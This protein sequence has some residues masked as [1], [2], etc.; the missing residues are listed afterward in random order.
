MNLRLPNTLIRPWREG[1]AEAMAR[2]ANNRKVWLN[3][4]DVFPHPYSLE[5]AR[6]YLA[7]LA[8]SKR[9]DS[10]AIEYEGGAVGGI[11]AHRL[12]DIHRCSA[13]IGYWL[14]EPYW[15]RGLMSEV[16]RGFSDKLLTDPELHRVFATPFEGNA[17]SL[18]VLEKA[19]FSREGTLSCAAIKGGKVLDMLM[20]AKCSALPSL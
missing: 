10:L 19:G 7:F 4:R 9:E 11:S 1:D 13:E 5:D 8:E 3:L 17:A 18:R 14:G 15:G 12:G 16:V 20:Y 6:S 2:N